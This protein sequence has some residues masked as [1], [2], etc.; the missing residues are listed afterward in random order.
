MNHDAAH[1]LLDTWAA[2]E[3]NGD[4]ETLMSL[5]RPDFLGVGPV[6][7]VLD[8]TRWAQRHLGDLTNTEFTLIEPQIRDY[9]ATLL[10]TAALRQATQARGMDTSGTFR[11]LLA[12]T[13]DPDTE[14]ALDLGI[15]HLQLSGPLIE[16]D[17]RPAFGRPI[18]AGGTDD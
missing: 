18:P 7:F 2:A 10:V 15:A 1:H 16:P 8:R 12:L 11:L 6:G 13:A 14:Q 9:G 4:V 3:L 5:L 17:E